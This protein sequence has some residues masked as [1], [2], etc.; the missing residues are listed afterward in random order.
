V[1]FVVSR[2]NHPRENNRQRRVD[3]N[4][5]EIH[6]LLKV[7]WGARPRNESP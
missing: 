4:E 3:P 2:G 6:V 5:K 7:G 1:A